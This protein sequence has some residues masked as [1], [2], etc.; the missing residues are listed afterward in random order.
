MMPLKMNAE[1]AGQVIKDLHSGANACA[2]AVWDGRLL[3]LVLGGRAKIIVGRRRS[4]R[5]P[6]K[7]VRQPEPLFRQSGLS[8][9]LNSIH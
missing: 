1:R 7:E 9:S 6:G 8:L 4:R 5:R 3:A 2:D